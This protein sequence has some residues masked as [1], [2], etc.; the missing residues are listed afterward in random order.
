MKV[1]ALDT[2]TLKRFSDSEMNCLKLTR[3]AQKADTAARKASAN[4][5]RDSRIWR[6]I[7]VDPCLS[8]ASKYFGHR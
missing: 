8:A 7:G 4:Y 2:G 1:L 5:V 3:L 6:P